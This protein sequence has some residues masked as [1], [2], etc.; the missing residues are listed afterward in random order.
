MYVKIKEMAE[1]AYKRQNKNFMDETFQKII[2]ICEC[3][4]QLADAVT[5]TS[6]PGGFGISAKADNEDATLTPVVDEI[7]EHLMAIDAATREPRSTVRIH[8]VP[9]L[10]EKARTKKG[11]AK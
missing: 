6:A 1:A 3:Q 7:G 10:V 5:L 11:G 9:G 2:A 8:D 4:V